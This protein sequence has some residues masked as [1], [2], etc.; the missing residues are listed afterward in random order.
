MIMRVLQVDIVVPVR[1]EEHDLASS[2][3]RLVGYLRE[4]FPFTAR[5]T[6]A[7]NGSTDG[8]WAIASRLAREFGEVRAVR[9]EQP[10][11]GRALR[12]IWS[13]SDAEVL[14]YMDVDLSTD[15]NALLPLVAPLLSGHSDLA[16]G[17]R[18]ARGSRVI[19][20]P[21]RELISRCY[22]M[23]LHACMGARFSDA[24]CGFK[25]IRREQARALL[26]LTQDTGWFFDTE[27]L[28]LAER[29]GLRIHEIPVDW[30]DDLDSRVDIVATA[31]ADLRG[32][33]RLGRGLARGSISVPWLRGSSPGG[34][35]RSGE[36]PLQIAS[37]AVVGIAST[38]AYLVLY[39]LLRGVMS[40]QTANVLSLL[41]TAVANT[42]ANRRLT[43]GISGR[44]HAARHQVKGLIAFGIGLALTSGA[45]AALN[46]PSR[47]V[48]VSVLVAA[49]LVATVIRFVLYRTWIF[50]KSRA[51]RGNP[52]PNRRDRIERDYL[53]GEAF[54]PHP[55][56]SHPEPGPAPAARA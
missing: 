21:K 11:R 28:V 32:M 52:P 27:L 35:R 49:N 37:F 50:G 51:G 24:Q 17:T 26:P 56:A 12:A 6:I 40:A 23:L 29:A 33:A 16:I 13:Q 5:I 7:D 2:V 25:A 34:G 46:H 20:G 54:D 39:L 3:R 41:V 10:G 15:L 47:G 48:E 19:R 42:A 1:N 53:R 30:I 18:L 55:P 31:V 9:M 36:L 44:R 38:I 45:L 8:T 4:G 14:A 22:N 43:F